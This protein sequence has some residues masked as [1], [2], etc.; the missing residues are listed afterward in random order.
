MTDE[1]RTPEFVIG[2]DFDTDDHEHI[3]P[4]RNDSQNLR[5]DRLSRRVTLMA[6]LIPILIGVI[7]YLGY[8]DISKKVLKVYDSGSTVASSL[9]KELESKFSNLSL[10]ISEIED[11]LNKKNKAVENSLAKIGNEISEIQSSQKTHKKDIDF[12]AVNRKK[13]DKKFAPIVADIKSMQKEISDTTHTLTQD[14]SD[15]SYIV[16]N[17]K[18]DMISFKSQLAS[19]SSSK[20]SRETFDAEIN[21]L[22]KKMDQTARNLEKKIKLMEK[23]IGTSQTPV[24]KTTPPVSQ[25][26]QPEPISV[27]KETIQMTKN[28]KNS[29]VIEQELTE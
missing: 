25:K 8:V 27:E 13:T 7:C 17:L 18:K 10:H 28:K 3:E 5:I 4:A 22:S 11:T 26:V 21:L 16:N 19:I 1:N 24:V 23:K 29:I 14:V 12:L 2:D 9:S 6:V 15:I 20:L